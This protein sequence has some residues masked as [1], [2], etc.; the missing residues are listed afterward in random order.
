M[1]ANIDSINTSGVFYDSALSRMKAKENSPEVVPLS[2]KF[3]KYGIENRNDFENA[4]LSNNGLF[5]FVT[6]GK[7][8]LMLMEDRDTS[9]DVYYKDL[10]ILSG[11]VRISNAENVEIKSTVVNG[12]LQIYGHDLRSV[13]L[14][15]VIVFGELVIGPSAE[16]SDVSLTDVN[17]SRLSFF[18]IHAH[19]VH[20]SWMHSGSLQ[21]CDAEIS[22]LY[23]YY[24]IFQYFDLYRT[25]ITKSDFDHRQIALNF[26]S[27]IGNSKYRTLCETTIDVVKRLKSEDT[28]YSDRHKD[29][30]SETFKY[31]TEN[32]NFKTDR[33]LYAKMFH[34]STLI[35]ASN[36]RE[37]ILSYITQSFLSP[38][39]FLCYMLFFTI[40]FYPA[41]YCSNFSYFS[42][43]NKVVSGLS[44]LDSMYFSVITFA[45]L[46]YGDI[47]PSSAFTKMV[48]ITEVSLGVILTPCFL[49]SLVKKYYEK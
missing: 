2:H 15:S 16:V 7:N 9:P 38:A 6:V 46:G 33:K 25:S 18:N 41:I 21:F 27:N 37:K 30:V 29:T 24:C 35:L 28:E 5:G 44:A 20:L 10:I 32:F 12:N 36:S 19:E 31:M 49:L 47:V 26:F 43:G 48:A 22:R 17:C 42:C 4:V 23:V 8:E 40:I 1:R 14:D 34:A 3:K 45:T 39:L 11:D 13:Q